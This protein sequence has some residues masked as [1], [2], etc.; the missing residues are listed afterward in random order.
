MRSDSEPP[1]CGPHLSINKAK[2]R[3]F[4]PEQQKAIVKEVDKLTNVGFIK[5]VDYPDWLANIVLVKKAN[6]KWGIYIDFTDLNKACPKY[7]YPLPRINQLVDATIDHELLTFMNIFSG[8][9]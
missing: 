7:N 2:K 9:N 3:S 6:E 1:K 4:I 8:Y 5:E